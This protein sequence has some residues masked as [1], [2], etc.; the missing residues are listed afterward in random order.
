MV[1]ASAR[2]WPP[3]RRLKPNGKSSKLQRCKLGAACESLRR[4]LRM[5][6]CGR[7]RQLSI[8]WKA[9]PSR[10]HLYLDYA[11]SNYRNPVNDMSL[12]EAAKLYLAVRE[13]DEK[14]G[15]ISHRQFTS[16]QCELRALEGAFRGKKV[17]ELGP[18]ALTDYSRRDSA[19]KKTFNN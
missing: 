15:H 1:N 5:I 17:A 7:Q 13:E 9:A 16:F 14:L 6:S 19:S 2:I 4:A 12:T 3:A 8:A 10:S 11:L 18:G